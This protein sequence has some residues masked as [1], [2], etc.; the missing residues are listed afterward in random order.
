M[1]KP[2]SGICSSTALPQILV[3]TYDAVSARCH[4]QTRHG[5][6]RAEGGVSDVLVRLTRV[7]VCARVLVFG[8]EAATERASQLLDLP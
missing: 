7:D 8:Q 1:S 5:I 3:S 2:S 4:S 6:P